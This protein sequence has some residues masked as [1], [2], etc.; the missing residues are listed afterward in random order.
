[1]IDVDSL[2]SKDIIT[3]CENSKDYVEEGYGYDE[4]GL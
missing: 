4:Q 3:K 1:M 2:S